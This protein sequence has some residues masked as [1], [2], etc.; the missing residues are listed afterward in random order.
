MSTFQRSIRKAVFVP[1]DLVTGTHVCNGSI[2]FR[3][4]DNNSISPAV[5]MSEKET[6]IVVATRIECNDLIL[7]LIDYVATVVAH[8]GIWDTNATFLKKVNK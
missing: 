5:L 2:C 4:L 1:G 3:S 6:Y 8:G 7:P